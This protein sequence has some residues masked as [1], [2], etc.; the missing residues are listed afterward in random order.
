VEPVTVAP[1]DPRPDDEAAADP[2]GVR[3][4][5][6]SSTVRIEDAVVRRIE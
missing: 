1:V 5:G 2:C 4:S 3:P 6:E